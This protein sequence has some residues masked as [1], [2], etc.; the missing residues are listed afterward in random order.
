MESTPVLRFPF[1]SF[2]VLTIGAQGGVFSTAGT[3]A[4]PKAGKGGG[5]GQFVLLVFVLG[6]GE[7]QRDKRGCGCAKGAIIGIEHLL[8][9]VEVLQEAL[10][11]AQQRGREERERAGGEE[12]DPVADGG[13]R[14]V[15]DEGQGDAEDDPTD[16][17]QGHRRQ[18]GEGGQ[19]PHT[20]CGN[21]AG[22]GGGGGG[23]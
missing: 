7:S 13:G 4:T 5:F 12:G 15:C 6:R 21:D 20:P 17:R 11:R 23:A 1:T 8:Q 22:G 9:S 19:P 18:R 10:R 2:S 14:R 16:Q 3:A